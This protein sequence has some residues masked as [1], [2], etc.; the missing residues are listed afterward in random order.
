MKHACKVT[1]LDKKC[2]QDLQGKYLADPQ[3]GPCPCFEVGQT[4][5]L[6]VKMARMIFG[7]LDAT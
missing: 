5:C 6:S 7:I 4:F 3:S 1:V 2:F